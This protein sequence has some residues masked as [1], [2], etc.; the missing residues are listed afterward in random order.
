MTGTIQIHT[1][2]TFQK[3]RYNYIRGTI[4]I[5]VNKTFQKNVFATLT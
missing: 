1:I 5:H 4:Q 3:E 2:K